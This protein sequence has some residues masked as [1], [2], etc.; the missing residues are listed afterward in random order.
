[1][2]RRELLAMVGGAAGLPLA[3]RAQPAARVHR[4]GFLGT[5]FASGY[6]REVEWI[7]GGLRDLGY[8]EG[9][10]LIVEYRW[11]EGKPER[12]REIAAEFVALKVDAIVVHGSPGA[13]AAAQATSTI[14]IV[15]ADG[16]DP[17]AIGLARSLA[18]PGGNV[19]GST[20]FVREEVGKRLQLIQELVPS[21]R[22]AGYLFSSL[23]PASVIALN[24]KELEVAAA[25]T[26]T[27][28]QSFEVHSGSDLSAAFNAMA[29]ARIDAVVINSEP[30]LNS[31][32]GVIAG[33]AASKRIP[34]VGYA[35]Y[36]DAGGL[37]AYGANR[38]ALYGRTGYF[39]D[40]IFKGAKPA[41]MPIEQAAKF[42]LV[43]NVKAARALGVAVPQLLLLRAD[44]V[45][46]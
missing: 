45:I 28:V 25:L 37:L 43:V 14:P 21:A 24:R 4:I 7:R 31:F 42:D 32:A 29:E 30:L 23:H 8:V 9:R 20:S 35:A 33:L 19:T 12:I 46:D 11:A 2:R 15:M 22:R 34:A 10:N 36:A 3:G 5:A 39:L 16:A 38:E 27:S 44:R 41:E 1:M 18:R 6:V 17:V 40:R 26:S 13:I